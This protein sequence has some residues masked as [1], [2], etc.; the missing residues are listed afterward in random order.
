[1]ATSLAPVFEPERP[2]DVRR[3]RADISRASELFGYEPEVGF[4]EGLRRTVDY[5]RQRSEPPPDGRKRRA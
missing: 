4:E 1:M 5:F 2:G 3:T